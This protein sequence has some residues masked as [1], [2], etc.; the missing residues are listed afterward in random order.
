MKKKNL[1][2]YAQSRIEQRRQKYKRNFVDRQ[3]VA[4]SDRE[5]SM[6]GID[7]PVNPVYEE[8][9]ESVSHLLN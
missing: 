7:S 6:W 2:E 3:C 4:R 1:V 8:D 5:E 9:K